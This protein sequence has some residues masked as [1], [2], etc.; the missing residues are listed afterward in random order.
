MAMNK[1]GKCEVVSVL[2]TNG[3]I[4]TET[5]PECKERVQRPMS[6]EAYKIGEQA[7]RQ[8]TNCGK[9]YIS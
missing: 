1:T 6:R 5:C 4:V 8:C 7:K 3:E 9:P 2:D